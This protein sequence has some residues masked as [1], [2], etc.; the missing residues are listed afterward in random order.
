MALPAQSL[1]RVLARLESMSALDAPAS[2]LSGLISKV[3]PEG[4]IKDAASGTWLGHPLHPL[5]VSLPIGAWSAAS[6]LDFTTGKGSAK[7]A[8]RLVG[9]G[10][11]SALPTAAAGASD[12]VDTEGAEKRVGLVHLAG[13]WTSIAIYAASWKAR[14]PG[15]HGGAT[16]ALLGAGALAAAGYLGGH[17]SYAYGVGVDTTAFEGGPQDWT[18]VAADEDIA[19]GSLKQVRVDGVAILLVRRGGQLFA[20]ADRCTHRGAPLSEGSLE[21]GCV[22]CPWHGSKFRVSDGEIE[23]GPASIPQPSYDLRV[24]EGQVRVRRTE[25]RA[26]RSNPA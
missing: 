6:V 3:V 12:W 11:L 9:F 22:V 8:R 4:P 1:N 23:R 7:A 14:G 2:T 24:V 25:E 15:R 13:A 5:L 26:L 19:E 18:T 21:D 10:L 20:L 16:L 17:L